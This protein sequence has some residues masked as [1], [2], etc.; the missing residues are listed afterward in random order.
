MPGPIDAVV[1]IDNAFRRDIAI[2]DSAA[3]AAAQGQPGTGSDGRALPV[4]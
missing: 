3:L 1:A 2:I 4:L